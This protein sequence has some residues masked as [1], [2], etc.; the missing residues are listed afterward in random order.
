[1]MYMLDTNAIIMAIRHP[2]WPISSKI[3]KHLGN[4]LYLVSI[5][6]IHSRILSGA[7]YFYK[8]SEPVAPL[9]MKSWYNYFRVLQYRSLLQE[10]EML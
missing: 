1:M 4:D 10:G 5:H 2:D 7:E 9:S 6:L 3:E 8:E